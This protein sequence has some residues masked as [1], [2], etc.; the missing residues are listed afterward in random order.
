MVASQ[1]KLTSSINRN[2]KLNARQFMKGLAI[3]KNK[4]LGVSDTRVRKRK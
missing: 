4:M 3:G 2:P 1:N